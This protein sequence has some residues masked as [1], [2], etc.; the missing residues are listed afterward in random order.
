MAHFLISIPNEWELKHCDK[1]LIDANKR[2]YVFSLFYDKE[3][4]P[5]NVCLHCGGLVVPVECATNCTCPYYIMNK[6]RKM[7]KNIMYFV[8][9][10]LLQ[11]NGKIKIFQWEKPIFAKSQDDE[12]KQKEKAQQV[13]LFRNNRESGAFSIYVK[14]SSLTKLALFLEKIVHEMVLTC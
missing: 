7:A 11:H 6:E 8:H 12:Q 9:E 13:K 4:E 5:R 1:L 3:I 10:L 14:D 2:G